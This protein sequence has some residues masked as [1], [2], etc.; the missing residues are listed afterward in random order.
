MIQALAFLRIVHPTP[1]RITTA[2]AHSDRTGRC[3]GALGS[4]SDRTGRCLAE[5]GPNSDRTG[6]CLGELRHNFDRTGRCLVE[7][8]PNFD[9]AGRC[10][11][12]L[13]SNSDRTGQCLGDL[14]HNFDRTERCLV[15]LGSNFDR[16][17]RCL[18]NW[19]T[20]P[21]ADEIGAGTGRCCSNESNFLIEAFTSR[22]VMGEFVDRI[23]CANFSVQIP[24]WF[25]SPFDIR[26][27]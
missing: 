2:I 21:S 11:G 14:G 9:R 6:R 15:E 1:A 18:A 3:L 24:S 20:I 12:A 5:L 26:I 8:V 27:C 22:H 16:T 25:K 10:S 13:G 17:G 19:D 4:N 23:S 7:L